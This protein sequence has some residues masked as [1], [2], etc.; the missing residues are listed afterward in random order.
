[1]HLPDA[2]AGKQ[3]KCPKCQGVVTV[4]A[5]M[6]AAPANPH[7]EEFWSELGAGNKSQQVQEEG[8][9]GQ[10]KQSDAQLLKR[11]LGKIEEQEVIKRTGL[12][13][14]S[15]EEGPLDRYWDTAIAITNRP[16]ETWATMK[17]GGGM[18][19]P[20]G[21]LLTGALFGSFFNM[22][23]ALAAQGVVIFTLFKA[24]P[25]DKIPEGIEVKIALALAAYFFAGFTLGIVGTL[26][27]GYIQAGFLQL[28]LMMVGVKDASYEK[29]FRVVAFSQGTVL[30]W[31]VVPVLGGLFGLFILLITLT[32]GI[33]VTYGISQGKAFAAIFLTALVLPAV[34]VGIALVLG[35]ILGALGVAASL[36]V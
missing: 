3:G 16:L 17:L 22:M 34:I 24:I 12:P 6:A 36:T 14:E 15:S 10:P 4:P 11:Q 21:F 28:T 20:F 30:V 29:T 31:T 9:H 7:D 25:Q 2:A 35:L 1:M 8:S 27:G 19:K 33:S 13:W 26:L 23:Y 18:G 5:A 32:S